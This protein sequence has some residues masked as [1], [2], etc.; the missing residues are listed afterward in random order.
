MSSLN[1]VHAAF[2]SLRSDFLDGRF[3]M[4]AGRLSGEA[5]EWGERL[6]ALY[7]DA[8]RAELEAEDAMTRFWVLRYRGM[9]EPA[10]LTGAPGGAAFVMAFNA[11]PYLDLM[12]DSWGLGDAVEEAGDRIR[13]RCLFDGTDQGDVVTAVRSARG[14]SFDL[15]PLYRAKAGTFESF[16]LA[17]YGDFDSF[18]DHYV[19]EHDLAFDLDQAWRPLT[20]A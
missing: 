11:F 5:V 6:L 18:V 7:R 20:G 16:V 8:G 4:I 14:W 3:P 1:A 2:D 10:D 17:E 12:M 19:A 15:M 9:P 13:L